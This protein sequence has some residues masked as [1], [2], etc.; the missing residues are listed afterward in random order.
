MEMMVMAMQQQNAY[1]A[2]MNDKRVAASVA[3]PVGSQESRDLAEFR[4]CSPIQFKGDTDPKVADHWIC[5]MEKMF[6]V[7]RYSKERKLAYAIYMLVREVEYWWRGTHQM[8]VARGVVV[9]WECFKRVFL[10]KYFL[11]SV[12]H[13]KEA[14]FIKLHQGSLTVSDY[15]MKFEHL[16]RFFIHR[17]SLKS[18]S[19]E[20]LLKKVATGW[21]RLLRDQLGPRGVEVKGSLMIGPNH[22]KGGPVT[23]KHTDTTRSWGQSGVATLRC[24][25]CGGPHFIRDCPHTN[26]K[27]FRCGQVGHMS[28][29][30]PV[31]AR[32]TRSALRGD[33]STVA[34]RVFTLTRAEASTSSDLVK[35]KGK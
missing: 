18:G 14:E 3:R 4:K 19:V 9:D 13:S 31:G 20:S 23:R 17:L 7:L 11:E 26:S 32:Q 28:I 30:C 35:G 15:A 24:Y 12:R 22:N 5:E 29:S 10:E 21:R 6:T 1:F 27:C 16:A 8:L 34:E 33:R 2:R 25:R